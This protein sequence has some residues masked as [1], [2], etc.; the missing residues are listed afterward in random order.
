MTQ[1]KN[2]IAK[3]PK[4]QPTQANQHHLS[5]NQESY[6]I[7]SQLCGVCWC[8]H[9]CIGWECENALIYS[10]NLYL[11]N[12]T[13][14]MA[15]NIP[16]Q[17]SGDEPTL[18]MWGVCFNNV[19]F[20]YIGWFNVD[21]KH[22]KALAKMSYTHFYVQRH[23]VFTCQSKVAL[24]HFPTIVSRSLKFWRH[25]NDL[26]FRWWLFLHALKTRL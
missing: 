9:K 4:I 15:S 10:L 20:I 23:V 19:S 7:M 18:K 6:T 21:Y 13:L 24:Q 8:L 26:K 3:K 5:G 1:I 14:K 16:H 12:W 17:S 25:R 11:N 22:H 2:S